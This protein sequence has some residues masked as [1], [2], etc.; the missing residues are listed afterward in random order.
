MV[1][2][3]GNQRLKKFIFV[4][5]TDGRTRTVDDRRTSG[6]GWSLN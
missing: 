5:N 3:D 4:K 2:L 6:E 1:I